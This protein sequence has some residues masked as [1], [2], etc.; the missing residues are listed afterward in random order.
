MRTPAPA[1]LLPL[2]AL[3]ASSCATDED[4]ARPND[5][6][7][8]GQRQTAVAE[9]GR[10]VMPFD[11]ERTTHVFEKTPDGGLQTVVSDDGDAEQIALIREHLAEEAERF[12]GGDFHDPEMIHGPE[13]AGLHALVTGHDRLDIAYAEVDEGAEIRYSSSDP[14]LVEAL[15]QWFDAQLS[16]HGAHAQPHR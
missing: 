14:A 8:A 13:M 2:V 3:V 7:E 15:H 16:D 5:D 4:R 10:D 9:A 11:L 12:A 6:L 1:F